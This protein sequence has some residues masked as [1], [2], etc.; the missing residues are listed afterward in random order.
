MNEYEIIGDIRGRIM[1]PTPVGEVDLMRIKR[2]YFSVK[3]FG[4]KGDGIADDTIA[5]QK[6]IDKTFESGGGTVFFP[7]GLYLITKSLYLRKNVSIK[8][9]G[10]DI[11]FIQKIT[12][13]TFTSDKTTIST[14]E[15]NLDEDCIINIEY[16]SARFFIE[17]IALYSGTWDE[18]SSNLDSNTT[19]TKH[20]IYCLSANKFTLTNVMTRGCKNGIYFLVPWKANFDN[21]QSMFCDIAFYLG[22]HVGGVSGTTTILKNCYALVCNIGFLISGMT[23]TQLIACSVDHVGVT[24]YYFSLCKNCKI[25]NSSV[26]EAATLVLRVDGS[27]RIKI[28]GLNISGVKATDPVAY[29]ESP[30]YIQYSDVILENVKI[31]DLVNVDGTPYTNT[32]DIYQLSFLALGINSFK[33]KMINCSLPSNLKA[34]YVNGDTGGVSAVEIITLDGKRKMYPKIP[35]TKFSLANVL[36]LQYDYGSAIPTTNTYSVGSV[37][38]NTNPTAGG[39]LG[40]VCVTAGTPGIWKGFGLI[41]A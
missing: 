33:V 15:Y 18:N 34:G 5:I 22:Y 16:G 8:G 9:D 6:A 38:W 24:A 10:T 23:T 13:N 7:K 29:K 39:Y 25:D 31:A 1:I 36:N 26:E 30:L 35:H 40:W 28:S 41:Q 12:H 2:D 32:K 17:D 3:D 4:A 11:T 19:L 14:T 37:V 20:G 27:E 21:C